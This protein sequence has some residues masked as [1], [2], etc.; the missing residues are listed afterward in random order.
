MLPQAIEV[1]E[2]WG[3]TYKTCAVWSKDRIG[4]GYWFRNKHEIL[5]IGT[6]GKVPAPAM[7]TQW[8]SLILA[9]VGRHSEKPVVF[10]EMIENYFPTLPKIELHA[11]GV[12][13]RPGWDVWGL[14]AP[15][16]VDNRPPGVGLR[17]EGFERLA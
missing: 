16:S 7:G 1:M 5:L 17:Q 12:V 6:R 3:F 4:T 8:P 13:S 11:R 2:A 14:E 10:C 9:P 15:S